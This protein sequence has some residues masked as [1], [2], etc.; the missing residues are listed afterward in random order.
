LGLHHYLILH[1]NGIFKFLDGGFW[2]IKIIIPSHNAVTSAFVMGDGLRHEK[3]NH[4]LIT[5]PTEFEDNGK[6]EMKL[7]DAPSL[8]LDNLLV[9]KDRKIIV[10]GRLGTYNGI[11]EDMSV[12]SYIMFWNYRS[13]TIAE[14]A[15]MNPREMAEI[16]KVLHLSRSVTIPFERTSFHQFP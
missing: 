6:R 14:K 3:V 1:K 16:G 7:I 11:V 2:L 5:T 13:F 4:T 15:G 10:V 9:G 8:R 12:N